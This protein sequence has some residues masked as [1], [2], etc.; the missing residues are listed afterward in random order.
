MTT[1]SQMALWS[2]WAAP[3][4]MSNDLRTI[5]SEFREILQNREVIAVDQDPLGVQAKL[6]YSQSGPL[7]N[8]DET[9]DRMSLA[10]NS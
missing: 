6:L 9:K 7:T 8:N 10:M 4:L 1:Q 3:L 2:I 5:S